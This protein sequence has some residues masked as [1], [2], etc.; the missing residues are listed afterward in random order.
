MKKCQIPWARYSPHRTRKREWPEAVTDEIRRLR[1][2]H[3]NLGKRKIHP[4]LLRFCRRRGLRCPAVITIGRL[5]AD[6]GGLRAVPPRLDNRGRRKRPRPPKPRKPKGFRARHPGEVLA[7]DTVIA[8]RDGVRRY[9]FACLDLRSR[10]GLAVATPGRSSHWA[11]DF[12]DLAFDLFPGRVDRVLSDNGSEHEGEFADL[13]TARGI[14]RYYTYPKTP[15]MNAHAERFNRTVQ[16]EFLDYHEDLLWGDEANLALLN[17]KLG[18]WLLWYNGERPHEALG[19][20]TPIAALARGALDARPP[21]PTAAAPSR[22]TGDTPSPPPDR[23]GCR[24]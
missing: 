11:R 7:V 1:A 16:E 22:R 23:S 15:K 12:A 3:P 18:E 8:A 19:Q 9:L 2:E 21:P 13:L 10:F 24:Q 5:I 6:A 17:R 20:R 4:L 14:A